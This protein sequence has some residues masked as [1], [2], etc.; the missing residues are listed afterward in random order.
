MAGASAAAGA[1]SLNGQRASLRKLGQIWTLA[2]AKI[3]HDVESLR[4]ALM[5][6][7]D[8]D[9]AAGQMAAAFQAHVDKIFAAFDGPLVKQLAAAAAAAAEAELAKIKADIRGTIK[10]HMDFVSHDTAIAI[11]DE[12]PLI[13]L[14]IAALCRSTLDT[15]LR[16]IH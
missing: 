11:M 5:K 8:G 3:R 13:E 9:A 1:G 6:L 7:Y 4:A 15:M 14:K 16:A 2:E 10:A 12:N